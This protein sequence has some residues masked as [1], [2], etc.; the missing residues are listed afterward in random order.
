[1]Y[2]IRCKCTEGEKWFEV[3]DEYMSRRNGMKAKQRKMCAAYEKKR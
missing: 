3:A 2:L 1:M